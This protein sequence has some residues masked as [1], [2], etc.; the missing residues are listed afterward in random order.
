MTTTTAADVSFLRARNA[1]RPTKPPPR[2]ISEYIQGRRIMPTSSPKPGPWDNAYTPYLVDLMNDLSPYSPVQEEVLMKGAQVGGTAAVENV[3]GYFMDAAPA[4]LQYVSATEDALDDWSAK[5]LEPLID[6]LGIR[7]KIAPQHA[8]P[9]R[10]RSGDKTLSKEYPG[11]SL[12]MTSAQAAASLRSASRRVLVLDELDGAPAQLRTGEGNYAD[13]AAART[14]AWGHRRKIM[15]LSTP[16]TWEESLIR[17][18]YEEGDCQKY[19]VPCPHCERFQELVLLGDD[20]AHGLKAEIRG[21]ELVRAFYVCEKCHEEIEDWQ[22]TGMLARGRWQ[23][24]KPSSSPYL[25]SRHLSSLYS[26]VGMLSWTELYRKYLRAREDPDGMR[27]FTNLY[28]G[29]PYRETGARPEMRTVIALRGTYRQRTIPGDVDA[30]GVWQ[31]PLYLTMGVDV[32][33]GKERD[34]TWGPRLELEIL[35]VGAGYRTWSIDRRTFRGPVGDPYAG[36]WAAMHEWAEAGGLAFP[37]V[38]CVRPDGSLGPMTV[39]LVLIDSGDGETMDAVYAFAGRWQGTLP[40]K[41]LPFVVPNREKRERGDIPGSAFKKY[42]A[43]QVGGGH[44]II[45]VNTRFYK[46]LIYSN[47]RVPRQPLDPQRPGFC[48]FPFE[49]DE[50]YF[51]QLTAEEMRADGSFHKVRGRNESLDVRCYA[52]CASDVHLDNLVRDAQNVARARGANLAALQTISSR[53]MLDRTAR[54]VRRKGK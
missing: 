30:S 12:R 42:R 46:R 13:V 53:W 7:H 22:K 21:G 23:A 50:E 5:R 8:N 9:K 37:D 38:E 34:D 29:L 20:G 4:D 11:G 40:C 17:R 24:T 32:Q 48:D 2:L 6:S 28:L 1:L 45:E 52:L 44:T 49:Y 18:K 35:G 36:A 43:A 54:M 3:L 16:G 14:L 51:A 25:V 26:P 33:R 27:S 39:A 41:G 15:Y 47:L 19:L 31:G 10:R